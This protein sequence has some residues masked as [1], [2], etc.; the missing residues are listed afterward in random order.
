MIEKYEQEITEL[1]AQIIL[2]KKQINKQK[3]VIE[4]FNKK[5]K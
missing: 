2:L 3:E 4:K 1:K 5:E